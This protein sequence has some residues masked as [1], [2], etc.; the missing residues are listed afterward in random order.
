[1]NFE[2]IPELKSLLWGCIVII[3]VATAL[4]VNPVNAYNNTT[5]PLNDTVAH[6]NDFTINH[7]RNDTIKVSKSATRVRANQIR[8]NVSKANFVNDYVTENLIN[9]TTVEGDGEEDNGN[10]ASRLNLA[11]IPV[12]AI[13][14]F[15]TGFCLKCCT[16]FRQYSRGSKDTPGDYDIV[17]A[18]D[19][20]FDEI[21]MRTD[22]ASTVYYDTVSSFCSF[23]RKN[24]MDISANT[25]TGPRVEQLKQEHNVSDKL[26]RDVRKRMVELEALDRKRATDK[27]R[28][29]QQ[30]IDCIAETESEE[31]QSDTSQLLF[32]KQKRRV[33]RTPSG[34]SDVSADTEQSLLSDTEKDTPVKRQRFKV[35]FVTEDF[36][37]GRTSKQTG[38]S[39]ILK[40][41]ITNSK[42]SHATMTDTTDVYRPRTQSLI[43]IQN[44]QRVTEYSN[45]IDNTSS[46]VGRAYTD[47]SN[48]GNKSYTI[49]VGVR[50][51]A[52]PK[53]TRMSFRFDRS[54]SLNRDR[55]I[56]SR[57]TA[58][59]GQIA[60]GA[61]HSETMSDKPLYPEMKDCA[62]QTDKSFRL[63]IKKGRKRYSSE[64]YADENVIPPTISELV[65]MCQCGAA[66]NTFANAVDNA[67]VCNNS[68]EDI[69]D[70]VF[71][72][73]GNVDGNFY[74]STTNCI[75]TNLSKDILSD[76][77]NRLTNHE[78][79]TG[80]VHSISNCPKPKSLYDKS[81]A[82]NNDEVSCN[83]VPSDLSATP[84][85]DI[86]DTISVS[87]HNISENKNDSNGYLL[88]KYC[89]KCHNINKSVPN[90]CCACQAHHFA[91]DKALVTD[92]YKGDKLK[93]KS[94]SHFNWANVTS[95]SMGQ[96][97]NSTVESKTKLYKR[98]SSLASEDLSV[99]S[100]SLSSSGYVENS[101]DESSE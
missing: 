25:L 62:V 29:Q 69:C 88:E 53:N 13:L 45:N 79:S 93:C 46:K 91:A 39:N 26:L 15:V 31:N 44:T 70:D 60:G 34:S 21:E 56:V 99:S 12:V 81:D 98:E 66:K 74:S 18:G 80:H 67:C 57:N 30:D 92:K 2:I 65:E 94:C 4:T 51:K 83:L 19:T 11:V 17:E 38:D 89:D 55:S 1:M 97:P 6:V 86:T 16:W 50:P 14:V 40:P 82:R 48:F 32:S 63:S 71:E 9:V 22:S 23:L 43:P 5:S 7:Q 59:M 85:R 68:L 36:N 35:S 10:N 73:N 8:E 72:N 24:E 78:R 101:S 77:E 96:T 54:R 95:P 52:S 90:L 64:T 42:T 47:K 100:S 33:M 37:S 27:R 41:I 28:A 87:T 75:Q 20:D 3:T 58:Y 84:S 49:D 76:E 61:K